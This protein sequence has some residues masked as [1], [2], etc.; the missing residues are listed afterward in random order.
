M[1]F[2]PAAM[3][4][5]KISC[6]WG[7]LVMKMIKRPDT[8]AVRSAGSSETR[9]CSLPWFCARRVRE[10]KKKVDN[11]ARRRKI[12]L[13]KCRCLLMNRTWYAKQNRR[14]RNARSEM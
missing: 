4:G 6:G 10:K 2:G 13:E 3:P 1:G 12:G 8:G 11:A 14:Q 9:K 7:S 5:C